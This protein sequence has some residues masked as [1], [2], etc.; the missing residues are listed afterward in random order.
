MRKLLPGFLKYNETK[1]ITDLKVD[2]ERNVLYSICNSTDADTLDQTV[3]E[4][5]D[6]GVC[7]DK[8]SKIVTIKQGQVA[9]QLVEFL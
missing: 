9:Y 2:E 3:I 4:V 1:Q 5:F 7:S 6:L 8:F